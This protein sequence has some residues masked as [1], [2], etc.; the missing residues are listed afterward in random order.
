M[1]RERPEATLGADGR[2]RTWVAAGRRGRSVK[3]GQP[4]ENTKG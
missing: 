2:E 4:G 3:S 1:P